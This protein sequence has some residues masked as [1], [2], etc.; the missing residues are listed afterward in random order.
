MMA[1]DTGSCLRGSPLDFAAAG[2]QNRKEYTFHVRTISVPRKAK[3]QMLRNTT[4][5][6]DL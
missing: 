1:S 5:G 4:S 6:C 3:R 2:P